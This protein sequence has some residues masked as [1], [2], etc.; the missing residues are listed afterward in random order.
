M[1]QL[2]DS[3]T[4][5]LNLTNQKQGLYLVKITSNHQVVSKKIVL[6]TN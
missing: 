2:N 6:N 3:N 5:T 1:L 4:Y